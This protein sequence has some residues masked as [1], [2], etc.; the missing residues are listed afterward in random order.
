MG[1]MKRVCTTALLLLCTVLLCSVGAKAIPAT[2]QPE[3]IVNTTNQYYTYEEMMTDIAEL[4]AAYPGMFRS[5]IIGQ[6]AFGRKLPAFSIG[7]EN[8]PYTLALDSSTHGREY[9]TSL[10][11]MAQAEDLLKRAQSEPEIATLLEQVQVWTVPMLNPDGVM[12]SQQGLASVPD[13]ARKADLVLWNGGD[14]DF[15][16]WK[17][18]GRGVDLNRNQNIEWIPGTTSTSPSSENYPGPYALSEP[19]SIAM[20]DFLLAT[21]PD[22]LLNYHSTGSIIFWYGE[23]TGEELERVEQMANELSELTGY[24]LMDPAVSKTM[25][26][27]KLFFETAFG[28]PSFT[29]EV[30]RSSAPVPISEF[31]RIWEENKDMIPTLMRMV[32]QNETIAQ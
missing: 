21:Q 24:T 9:V 7:N 25:G 22:L 27:I 8:A 12:L 19:E 32:I 30:G 23:Q 28:K 29:V 5:Q 6:S 16:L 26:S 18:N 10:L 11:S 14:E 1:N 15:T 31:P 3:N 20:H 2:L 17:S 13:E 4:E